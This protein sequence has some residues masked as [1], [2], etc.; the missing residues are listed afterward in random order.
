MFQNPNT[1]WIEILV[2]VLIVG[3]ISF[4]IGR[5]FY[6]KT[7]GLPTGECACCAN[8]KKGNNLV[9]KYNKKYKNSVNEVNP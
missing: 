4:L 6:R 7:H 1:L 8:T 5:Y 3:F 2:L 9:K